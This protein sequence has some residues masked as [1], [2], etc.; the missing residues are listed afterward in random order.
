MAGNDKKLAQEI[1]EQLGGAANIGNYTHCMT[2]LRVTPK[3]ESL[4][5]KDAIK[6]I[7]GVIG[8]V[9]ADTLQMILGPGKVN[10]VTEEFVN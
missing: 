3:D 6:K 1:L 2:R 5:N 10:T 7:D 4:V 8:F 9:E